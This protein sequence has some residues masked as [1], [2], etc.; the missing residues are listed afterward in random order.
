MNIDWNIVDQITNKA[1]FFVDRHD[2]S[3]VYAEYKN[4]SNQLCFA[5][6]ESSTFAAFLRIWYKNLS[7]QR[8]APKVAPIFNK[9]LSSNGKL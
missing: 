1:A 8:E 7:N 2:P 3:T 9:A 4:G 5:N 6:I